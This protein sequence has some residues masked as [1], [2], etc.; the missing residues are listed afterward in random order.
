MIDVEKTNTRTVY[1]SVRL[2]IAD[3]EPRL[4]L[5]AFRNNLDAMEYNR[6]LV[7][8]V[9]DE[10]RDSIAE[11]LVPLDKCDRDQDDVVVYCENYD[12]TALD[13]FVNHREYE[14]SDSI[15]L[16]ELPLE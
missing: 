13:I 8:Q 5:H 6:Q 14:N 16:Q 10:W 4:F 11:D 15:Y 3:S 7:A 9:L 12:S 1:L 2:T